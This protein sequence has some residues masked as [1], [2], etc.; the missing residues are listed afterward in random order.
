MLTYLFKPFANIEKGETKQSLLPV[1]LLLFSIL[2]VMLLTT[3]LAWSSE[4]ASAVET[5][6][7]IS[8]TSCDCMLFLIRSVN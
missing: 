2:S 4:T 7:E 8:E 1:I 5:A 3:E 6:E